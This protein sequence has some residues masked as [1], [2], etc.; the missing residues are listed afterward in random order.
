MARTP[1]LIVENYGPIRKVDVP[2]ADITVLVGPQATGKSLALQW[3]KLA[4]DQDYISDELRLHGFYPKGPKDSAGLYFGAGYEDAWKSA[5]V[6]F[7][8]VDVNLKKIHKLRLVVKSASALFVPAHR[9]LVFT[10]GWPQQFRSFSPDTPYVVREFSENIRSALS[11]QIDKVVFPARRQFRRELVDSLDEALLHGGLVVM[12]S[13]GLNGE[14]LRIHHEKMN[15]SIMEWTT[16]QREVIPLIVALSDELP[17]GRKKRR[18]N[19]DWIIVEEPELGLHPDGIV[20]VISL[21]LEAARRGYKLV[22]STHSSVVLEVLWVMNRLRGKTDAP[23]RLLKMLGQPA[24]SRTGHQFARDILSLSTSITYFRHQQGGVESVDIT[25]L[26]PNGDG[27]EADWGGL[28]RYSSRS[29][30]VLSE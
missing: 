15:L 18:D 22:L 26:D 25:G 30:E 19:I 4:L 23:R 27:V 7:K 28:I 11:G 21:L 20:S 8:G 12:E 14:Q 10:T 5:T 2:F 3:L 24:D 29:A 17:V 13:R 9:S 1:H 16:G 6:T